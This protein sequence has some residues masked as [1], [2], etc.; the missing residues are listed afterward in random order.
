M[1][2]KRR[3]RRN[4][5]LLGPLFLF[6][7]FLALAT[8]VVLEYMDFQK[9]KDSFIFNK[10]VPL[11]KKRPEDPFIGHINRVLFDFFRKKSISYSYFL[12]EKGLYHFKMEIHGLDM[13]KIVS[14]MEKIIAEN[15]FTIRLS[16][17]QKKPDRIVALYRL[18]KENRVTHVI[19]ISGDLERE[20]I[21]K[22]EKEKPLPRVAF[23]IDDI[24]N[25]LGMAVELKRM[26]IPITAAVLPDSPFAFDEARQ[27][28]QYGLQNLIHLPMQPKN[29]LNRISNAPGVIRIDWDAGQ[30]LELIKRAR[31][32]VPSARGIN[33]HEGSMVT[34]NREAITR[35]LK[36]IKSEGMF[37]VDSR[38]AVD[39]VAFEVARELKIKTAFR[40]VF[41]DSVK[42][43]SHSLQQINKLISIA[44]RKGSAVAIGH[45]F[46]TT[47]QAI[48]DSIPL[49]HEKGIEIVFVSQIVE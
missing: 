1:S 43:Y 40:D 46:E 30:I 36:V 14:S 12:D 47:L 48:R 9:G 10:I 26:N 38:T 21:P 4:K 6:F 22:E 37:F 19:L 16:E 15:N 41:L 27:I 33:N 45:P 18:E 29:S 5:L 17:I 35:I 42:S 13:R 39:T 34:S 31:N 2:S 3:S 8:V 23:I 20:I 7:I 49:I 28:S 44:I 11:K 32:T 24:G 25:R